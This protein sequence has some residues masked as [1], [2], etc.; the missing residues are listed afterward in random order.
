M[1]VLR[2]PSP[3][4]LQSR[5]QPSRVSF[6]GD[7]LSPSR[8]NSNTTWRRFVSSASHL[9][10]R[11]KTVTASSIYFTAVILIPDGKQRSTVS[12]SPQP[13]LPFTVDL[14]IPSDAISVR[15]VQ[16]GTKG[17]S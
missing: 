13:S 12:P 1:A 2:P 4:P 3:S 17:R 16:F 11:E 8:R 14:Q 6:S 15:H 5:V 7:H 9:R 10:H